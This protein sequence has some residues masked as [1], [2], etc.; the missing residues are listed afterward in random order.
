MMYPELYQ[1][2]LQY[3][4]LTV[5]GIGTFL[6][7]RK[8]ARVDFPNKQIFPPV[9]SISMQQPGNFPA[10]DFFAWLSKMLGI[11]DRDAIVRFNDFAFD[12]KKQVDSG[13][14]IDWTGV[15]MIRKGLAGEIKFVAAGPLINEEPIPAAKVLRE[16]AEHTVRV[17]E[18]EKTS[19]QMAE[20][21][22]Q[23]GEKKSYWWALPLVM[24]LLAVIFIGWY[25]SEHGMETASSSNRKKLVPAENLTTYK[26]LP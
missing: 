21:L 17:G 24:V 2:L 3:K 7:E 1:Y 13:D 26:V 4:Q 20:M 12:M 9:F 10:R 23:P 6:V 5:P 15:G 19:V 18:E 8:P 22:A 16:N 11:S 25:L 14:A